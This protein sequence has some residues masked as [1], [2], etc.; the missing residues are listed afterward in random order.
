VPDDACRGLRAGEAHAFIELMP[1][2]RKPSTVL[3]LTNREWKALTALAAEHGRTPREHVSKALGLDLVNSAGANGAPTGFTRA[4]PG[5][6][7]AAILAN[8]R[9]GPLTLAQLRDMVDA[10]YNTLTYNLRRLA[11][12]GLVVTHRDREHTLYELAERPPT[13]AAAG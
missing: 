5:A 10:S 8:L 1:R 13:G 6:A 12:Q 9:T 7:R 11:R 2:G 4:A 3:R